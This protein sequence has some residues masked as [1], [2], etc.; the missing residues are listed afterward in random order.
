MRREIVNEK[1]AES[2]A[3]PETI[4]IDE[5][6]DQGDSGRR[7]NQRHLLGIGR[8]HAQA[9]RGGREVDGRNG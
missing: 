4:A 2:D 9:E 6:D 3:R 8:G 5:K 7:P 1:G